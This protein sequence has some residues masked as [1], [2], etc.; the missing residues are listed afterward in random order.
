[1]MFDTCMNNQTI[2]WSEFKFPIPFLYQYAQVAGGRTI[3]TPPAAQDGYTN[4][5][6]QFVAWNDC[7]QSLQRDYT[8]PPTASTLQA[9]YV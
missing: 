1:M 4:H 3:R 6:Y 9:I 5:R 8:V 7:S 2:D